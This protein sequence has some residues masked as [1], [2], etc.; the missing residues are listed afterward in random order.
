MLTRRGW[1]VVLGAVVL[2]LGGRILGTV[3]LYVLATGGL[4]LCGLSWASVWSGAGIDVERRVRPAR[5]HAGGDAQVELVV[6][7]RSRRR[8]PSLLVGDPF[9]RTA[10]TGTAGTG[11]AGSAAD[12]SAAGPRARF[13]L[14]PLRPGE[15]DG[16]R[17]RI[18]T[19]RGLFRIGPLEATVTDPFGLAYR[20]R[21]AGDSTELTVYPRVEPVVTPPSVA[22]DPRGG[23]DVRAT[24]GS[25]EEFYGLRPYQIGDDLRRVHWPS[26]ARQNDLM[27]RQPEQPWQ[28]RATI[29]LDTRGERAGETGTA[30]FEQAV[31]AAASIVTE[32]WRHDALVRLAT[33]GG[34]DSGPG[35][36]HHH[37]DALLEHLAV[38][39]PAPDRSADV[40]AGL[41]RHASGAL[42]VITG[43]APRR[44]DGELLPNLGPVAARYGWSALV[45]VGPAARSDSTAP[46]RGMRVVRTDAGHPFPAAWNRAVGATAA[47]GR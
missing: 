36:G 44:G 8:A 43:A 17:Y 22:R 11:A 3:E 27:I 21:R 20:L 29:L 6:T 30:G 38:V 7:N 33:T 35:T 25:G 4:A 40:L 46:A 12:G 41:G 34:F 19:E 2:A 26:T 9:T 47:A 37:L 45:L 18:A 24:L 32:C 15:T 14:A 16:A 10:G 1:A 39:A 28:G 42:V 5:A 23:A 31:S 13:Q